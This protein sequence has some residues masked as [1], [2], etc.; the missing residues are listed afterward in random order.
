MHKEG[1]RLICVCHKE[2]KLLSCSLL[3][4]AHGYPQHGSSCKTA[5]CLFGINQPIHQSTI[6]LTT[7][8]LLFFGYRSM[9]QH[10]GELA[11]G[12]NQTGTGATQLTARAGQ[13]GRELC[14]QLSH[15]QTEASQHS[16]ILCRRWWVL[17]GLL[18]L[19]PQHWTGYIG[20]AD[21]LPVPQS[22]CFP[23][24]MLNGRSHS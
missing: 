4:G 20:L 15:P 12:L 23:F 1:A 17:S 7:L 9:S 3:K 13:R 8:D 24:Q 10:L 19:D 2:R 14:L 22:L 5:S 18:V 6:F 21:L 16:C 11:Q